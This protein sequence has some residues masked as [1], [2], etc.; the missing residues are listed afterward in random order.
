MK[1]ENSGTQKEPRGNVGINVSV[2]SNFYIYVPVFVCTTLR[3][4]G[5]VQS[6]L[7]T[8]TM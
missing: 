5:A 1:S 7:L 4:Q 8:R 6:H 2:G 3:L